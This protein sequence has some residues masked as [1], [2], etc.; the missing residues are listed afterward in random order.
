MENKSFPETFKA[1]ISSRDGTR[2]S[3]QD[4]KMEPLKENEILIKVAYGTL[5]PSDFGTLDGF[6]PVYPGD[7]AIPKFTKCRVGIEGSGVV[8]ASGEN[9]KYKLE[10][11]TKVSFLQLGGMVYG[12]SN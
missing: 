11:G 2:G 9:C 4:V 12:R 3:F 7:Q 1:V 6:Y 10:N 8:V 5:N